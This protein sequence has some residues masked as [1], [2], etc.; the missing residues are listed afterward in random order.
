MAGEKKM[1]ATTIWKTDQKQTL[2]P[3]VDSIEKYCA[4]SL[5]STIES[6]FMIN[7]IPMLWNLLNELVPDGWHDVSIVSQRKFSSSGDVNFFNPKKNGTG[8]QHNDSQR[9]MQSNSSDHLFKFKFEPKKRAEWKLNCL[10]MILLL[11]TALEM[12]LTSKQGGKIE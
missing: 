9:K 8:K 3:G 5:Y 11:H 6:D 7:W 2:S 10:K 12:T 1:C 4:L